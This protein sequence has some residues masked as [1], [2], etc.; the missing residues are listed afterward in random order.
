MS[1]AQIAVTTQEYVEANY[2][3]IED[4]NFEDDQFNDK[5]KDEWIYCKFIPLDSESESFTGTLAGREKITGTYLVRCYARYNITCLSL[6]DLV[7]TMLSNKELDNNIII[8]SAKIKPPMNLE[9]NL[10]EGELHFRVVQF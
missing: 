4:I 5:D 7:K 2:P 3:D 6:M 9:D 10:Y 8:H 1:L